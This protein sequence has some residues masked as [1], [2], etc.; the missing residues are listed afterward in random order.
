VFENRVL[1]RV[2]GPKRDEVAGGCRKLHNE[3]L[4]NLYCSPAII[5]FYKVKDDYMGRTCSTN[6]E[7]RIACRILV[8]KPEGR[9]PLGRSR[10]RCVCNIKIDLRVTGGGGMDWIDLH[11]VAISS[12]LICR[13]SLEGA[14]SCHAFGLL[15][16]YVVTFYM[17]LLPHFST[18]QGHHQ[19]GQVKVKLSLCLTN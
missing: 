2:I 12:D 14:T 18:L 16:C 10:R 15:M 9:K 1:R 11:S 17:L 13:V 7:N 4:H 8:G 3:E 5:R 6:G 19:V